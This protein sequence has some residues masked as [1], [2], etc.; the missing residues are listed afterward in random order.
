MDG[1]IDNPKG[2]WK[3]RVCGRPAALTL[4]H[5]PA[6]QAGEGS[7][8]LRS[9]RE[10]IRSQ[11]E[12]HDLGLCS[13]AAFDVKGWFTLRRYSLVAVRSAVSLESLRPARKKRAGKQP[14][15]V[16]SKRTLTPIPIPVVVVRVLADIMDVDTDTPVGAAANPRAPT[17]VVSPPAPTTEKGADCG[18]KM[19]LRL[20]SAATECEPDDCGMVSIRTLVLSITPS[21]AAWSGQPAGAQ[22]LLEPV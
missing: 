21:T 20:E 13:F 16:F 7:I 1:R 19:R 5:V 2:G 22:F 15:L 11:L 18:T 6:P 9:P 4:A 10:R 17:A 14:A 3:A 8:A 12:L